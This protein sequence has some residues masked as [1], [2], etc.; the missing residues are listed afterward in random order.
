M[1]T[2]ALSTI[3]FEQMLSCLSLAGLSSHQAVEYVSIADLTSP[4]SVSGKRIIALSDV[5]IDVDIFD[6][7][8]EEDTVQLK[9]SSCPPNNPGSEHNNAVLQARLMSLPN[10]SFKKLWGSYV[11]FAKTQ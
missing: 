5:D 10:R 11:T 8:E 2:P 3:S 1:G 4:I 6:F 9:G 7:V